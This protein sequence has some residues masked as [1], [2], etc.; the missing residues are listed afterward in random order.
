M[1]M[2]QAKV[3]DRSA[4]LGDLDAALRKQARA[5][6]ISSARPIS[7]DLARS[8]RH[9]DAALLRTMQAGG[10]LSHLVKC[11]DEM[12]RVLRIKV[13]DGNDLLMARE[14][15]AELHAFATKLRACAQQT[16]ESEYELYKRMLM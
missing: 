13:E 9:R 16:G 14:A 8:Q 7:P 6:R 3:L 12:R 4:L 5:R 2:H 10:R 1:P 11:A 15:I